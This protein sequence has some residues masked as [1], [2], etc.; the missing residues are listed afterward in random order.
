[1]F[2][3]EQRSREMYAMM[4]MGGLTGKELTL[5]YARLQA[6]YGTLPTAHCNPRKLKSVASDL[7]GHKTEAILVAT[8]K[9]RHPQNP[10]KSA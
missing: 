2:S 5:H 9:S 1:M 8:Q 7:G 10:K 4:L 6:M 3:D